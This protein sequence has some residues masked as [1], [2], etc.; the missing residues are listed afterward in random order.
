MGASSCS[1]SRYFSEALLLEVWVESVKPVLSLRSSDAVSMPGGLAMAGN[2]VGME[3]S[4]ADAI[5]S[6]D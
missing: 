5:E 2:T 3:S 4:S 6:L 1:S